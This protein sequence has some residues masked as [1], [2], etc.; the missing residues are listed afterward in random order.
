MLD[1]INAGDQLPSASAKASL[2]RPFDVDTRM[3]PVGDGS[4]TG[5]FTG[6]WNSLGGAVNGGYVVACALQS[7]RQVLG[8]PDPLAVSTSFLRPAKPGPIEVSTDVAKTG[9]RTSTGTALLR[10]DGKELARTTATFADLSAVNPEARDTQPPAPVLPDPTDMSEPG[11][12]REFPGA[13]ITERVEFRYPRPPGWLEG[14]PTGDAT[15][16]FWLRFR[17]RPSDTM[18][19][20]MLVDAAAPAA[21]EL[22]IAPAVTIALTTHVRARPA[23]GWVACR[24][25]TRTVL[26]GYLEEDFDIWD[27]DGTHVCQARQLALILG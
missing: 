22:G 23:P 3:E 8:H 15:A 14:R 11:A 10:Q 21:L 18:S 9:R 26:G 13:T 7:L 6:R 16:E 1:R 2:D 25:T 20:P 5:A 24:V 12:G 17:D 19:L 27:A 4:F